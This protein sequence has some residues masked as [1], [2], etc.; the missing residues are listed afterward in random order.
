MMIVRSLAFGMALL[1]GVSAGLADSVT[2]RGKT[3][4][5]EL[6]KY[7][8]RKFTFKIPYSDPM[9]LAPSS[10]KELK[11]DMPLPISLLVSGSREPEKATLHGFERSKFSFERDGKMEALSSLKVKSFTVE[12]PKPAAGAFGGN[13]EIPGPRQFID[14]SQLEANPDLPPNQQAALKEYVD[15]R[16][17]YQAFLVESSRIVGEMDTATGNKRM[18]LLADL[19]ARKNA[20]AQMLRQIDTAEA[21]LQGAFPPAP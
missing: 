7:E 16:D 20:E 1:I 12:R 17:T 2:V 6:L 15:V 4:K 18:K 14:V 13:R 9:E 10:V 8:S 3:H 11:L 5:C 21:A 19:R